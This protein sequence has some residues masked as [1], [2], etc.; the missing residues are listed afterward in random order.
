MIDRAIKKA[1]SSP[2]RAKVSAIGIDSYGRVLGICRN[3]PRISK[4]GGGIHAEMNLMRRFD[5]KIKT[6]LLCRTNKTG[7]LLPIDPCPAC[8]AKAEDLGIKIYRIQ[9]V[10]IK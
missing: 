1:A 7:G 5:R 10:K 9:D 8:A 2:C 4:K 3:E 6:I